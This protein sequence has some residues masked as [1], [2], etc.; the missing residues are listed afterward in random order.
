MALHIHP[1]VAG[2]IQIVLHTAMDFFS[3]VLPNVGLVSILLLGAIAA[4]VIFVFLWGCIFKP[5]GSCCAQIG[6]YFIGIF[7]LFIGC[8]IA[9]GAIGVS[10]TALFAGAG[11]VAGAFV[12]AASD[13]V[14][15]FIVGIQLLTYGTLD[16]HKSLTVGGKTGYLRAIGLFTSEI[17]E[18]KTSPGKTLGPLKDESTTIFVPNRFLLSGFL[19]VTYH[20]EYR[21]SSRPGSLVTGKTQNKETT[22]ASP[23]TTSRYDIDVETERQQQQSMSRFSLPATS[24]VSLERQELARQFIEAS[25]SSSATS[26]LQRRLVVPSRHA[27]TAG[28]SAPKLNFV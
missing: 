18:N 26:V 2:D 22:T 20:E 1:D 7:I 23:T 6:Q 4:T 25:S 9:F 14:K 28:V 11:L 5:C 27:A 19:E 3:E 13:F 8:I 10:F 12:V 24:S 17:V 15:D 16:K 21:R